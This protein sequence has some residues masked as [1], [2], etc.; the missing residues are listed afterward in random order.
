M[1]L[2]S[3]SLGVLEKDTDSTIKEIVEVSND[4][5]RLQ[6]PQSPNL[7]KLTSV[8]TYVKEL[9]LNY[10]PVYLKHFKLWI[11]IL[12]TILRTGE[13]NI[14]ARTFPVIYQT[15]DVY[16][17]WIFEILQP[18]K[19]WCLAISTYEDYHDLNQVHACCNLY[20][21][22]INDLLKRPCDHGFRTDFQQI[23][24]IFMGAKNLHGLLSRLKKVTVT[25]SD[26]N[27]FA[28]FYC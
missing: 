1:N 21:C 22:V 12:G 23:E 11:Y 25:T 27:Q 4:V 5:K 19:N 2:L 3:L 20:L 15:L 9:E 18:N 26:T 17:K 16:F 14:Y 6:L 10:F 13:E 8:R 7:D 28:N 24:K